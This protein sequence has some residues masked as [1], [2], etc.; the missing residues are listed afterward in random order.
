LLG[1][2]IKINKTTTSAHFFPQR[3]RLQ[4]LIPLPADCHVRRSR[5]TGCTQTGTAP[6]GSVPVS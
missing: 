6:L 1:L 4:A 5:A 3:T 2:I